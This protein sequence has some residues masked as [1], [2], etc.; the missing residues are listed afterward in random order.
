MAGRTQL[1]TEVFAG[2]M[3]PSD[4]ARANELEI[5][6]SLESAEHWDMVWGNEIGTAA[7]VR[8]TPK[9][10]LGVPALWQAINLIAGDCGALPLEPYRSTGDGF[11]S[12]DRDHWTYSLVR[13]Q[14]N[15]YETAQEYW[16]TITAQALLY[17]N[18]YG[19]IWRD[20]SYRPSELL[21][22]LPDRTQCEYT[23]DGMPYYVS[24]IDGTLKAFRVEDVL[25][26][27]GISYAMLDAPRFLEIAKET[28]AA[29]LAAQNFQSRFFKN[30]GRTGGILELPIG[31]PKLARDQ[32]EEGFRKSYEG[33]DN[34]FK[35]VILRDNA[36][37]HS[38]QV[39]PRET[40]MVEAKEQAAREI[41]RFFNLPPSKLGIADGSSYNSKAED[42]SGYL[43]HCLRRWLLKIAGQCWLKLLTSADQ[44]RYEFR[45][46]TDELL[47]MD[48]QSRAAA[49]R[50]AIA[51]RWM[52]PNE[53]RAREG[54]APYDGGDEFA[55]PNTTAGSPMSPA[56]EPKQP[57]PTPPNSDTTTTDSARGKRARLLF[58]LTSTARHKSAN[59]R[60]FIEWLDGGF[61]NQLNGWEGEQPTFVGSI[62][63]EFEVV[64]TQ[65]NNDNL[66]PKVEAI[67]TTYEK[68]FDK[69]IDVSTVAQ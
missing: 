65:A 9:K 30:G 18:G 56:A 54:L 7:G 1:I 19:L 41:A 12:V 6:L 60:A 15:E 2:L 67:C 63:Q 52:N 11:Y 23:A 8:V 48:Q 64:V 47:R 42:G 59:P 32:V 40:Q 3:V 39:S 57:E 28:I 34:S 33:G 4:E 69:W 51:S 25:H 35:T 62:R 68:E 55:N 29:A 37:F 10:S 45:H 14:A 43:T 24:E 49:Y 16:E 21:H 31:M 61:R 22:L 58:V 46:D 5:A 50:I 27:R 20:G 53:V 66:P 36:K 38:A 17:G 26:V 44:R 13:R